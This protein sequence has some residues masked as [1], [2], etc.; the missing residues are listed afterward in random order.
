VAWGA[1]LAACC[2]LPPAFSQPPAEPADPIP[3]K[4]VTV[5]AAGAAQ[6]ARVAQEMERLGLTALDRIPIDDFDGR[7]RRARTAARTAPQLV[8]ARYFRAELVGDALVGKG[9]WRVLHAGTEA[10][11][12]PLGFLT[13]ALRQPRFDTRDAIVAEFEGQ[14]AGLLVEGE[15]D[16]TVN[17]DWSARQ[18]PESEGVQFQLGLP[19]CAVASLELDLPANL[20]VAAD[21]LPVTGPLLAEKAELKR[22]RVVFSRRPTLA[23]T[24][25]PRPEPGQPRA[26]LAGP[27]LT[28]QKL[29]S[30]AV[31]VDFAFDH[32]KVQSGEFRELTCALDPSL[33]PYDVTAPELE[34]WEVRPP[35]APGAP[36][37]LI[38]RLREALVSGTLVVRCFAPLG[39][40]EP[41]RWTAPG[42]RL[43]DAVP[44]GE[45]LLLTVH[46]DVSLD[47][48]EPGGFRLVEVRGDADGQV[49]KLVGGLLTDEAGKPAGASRPS[50]QLRAR[51]AEFRARQVALWKVDPE[52]SSFMARITYEVQRG[53]LFRLVLE[54]PA[55]YDL[56]GV[57]TEQDGQIRNWETRTE[58]GKPTLIVDLAQPLAPEAKLYLLVRLRP[59]LP[60]SGALAWSIPDL[61][62]LGAR[63]RE[64][65]LAIDFD[66]QRFEGRV[67]GAAM[68]TAPP[69][70]DYP[71]G[72]DVPDYYG[73]YRG[74]PLRGR[75]ELRPVPPRLRVRAA[76]RVVLAPGHVAAATTLQLQAEAGSPQSLDVYVSAAVPGR[77]DW[78]TTAGSNTVTS[79]KR[80]PALEAAARLHVLAARSPLGAAALLAAP[81]RGEWRRLTLRR[82]LKPRDVLT[83]QAGCELQRGADDRWDVPLL[84][85]PGADPA[86]GEV[87]LDLA[88]AA[89]ARIEASGLHAIQP[90]SSRSGAV[91]PW[92]T[93]R[94]G[95]PPVALILHGAALSLDPANVGAIDRA[96]LTTGV[97]PDGRLVHLFRFQAWG[98][99]APSLPLRL[100]AGACLLSVKVDGRWVE[101][102]PPI[103]GEDGGLRVDLPAPAPSDGT[104][105][106]APRRYEVVYTTASS[107][108]VLW[109]R[110]E[111]P[112]PGLPGPPLTFQRRW[113]LPPGLLP[114]YDGQVRALPAASTDFDGRARGT[115]DLTKL[116][117][118]VLRPLALEEW[119]TRQRDQLRAAAR[120]LPAGAGR[121]FTLGEAL[122]RMACD[123]STD[124]DPLV[125][126]AL[127]LE[128]AGLT[129]QTLL[130]PLAASARDGAPFWEALGLVQVPCRPAPLLTTQRRRDAWQAAGHDA[131][132]VPPAVEAAVAEA[133]ANGHDTSGR[134]QWAAAWARRSPSVGRSPAGPWLFDASVPG[135]TEWEP[136]AGAGADTALTTI[137][138]APIRA[139]GIALAV[140]LLVGLWGLRRQSVR[141]R[142]ALLLVGLAAAVAGL[143][144][145]PASLHGLALGPLFAGAALGLAWYLWSLARTGGQDKGQ[146]T[147]DKSSI[148]K[149]PAA[150]FVLCPLS[151]TLVAA[152]EAAPPSPTRATVLVVPGP[153]EAPD[154]AMVL[155]PHELV[156]Q[157]DALAS[158]GAPHGAVIAGATYDGKVAGADAEFEA[159]LHLQSFE[160]GLATLALPFADVRLQDDGLLDGARAYLKA[161]PTGQAGFVL[162][163]EKPGS[164]VLVMRF[165]VTVT[166]NG[167][168][169]EVRF[170]APRLPQSQLTLAVP[171]GAT[172]FQALVRQGALTRAE[173]PAGTPIARYTTELGR[174][175]GPL[176]FHWHEAVAAPPPPA[177]RV[178]EA[179]LWS[180][181]PDGASLQAVL[182]YSVTQGEPT[183][184]AVEVPEALEVLGAEARS[185]E[186]SRPAPLLKPW[187]TETV[188]GK[189]QLRLDF[190]API[191]GGVSLVLHLVPRRPLAAVA[192]LPLPNPLGAVVERGYLAYRTEG[193]EA[194]VANSGRLRGPFVGP[195]GA[196]ELKGYAALWQTAGE[197][198]PSALAV[199]YGVQREPGGDPFLQVRLSISPPVMM[200]T[201]EVT[202]RVGP[203]QADLRA[204]VRLTAPAGDLP[205][206]EWEVPADVAVTRVGGRGRR[207]PVR[208]WSRT[209]TRVQVWLDRTPGGTEVELSGWKELVPEAD[210]ARFD[211]PSVRLLSADVPTT[212]VRLTAAA[213]LGLRREETASLLPLPEPHTSARDMS[214]RPLGPSYSGRFHVQR[215][216]TGLGDGGLPHKGDGPGQGL[217]PDPEPR[218]EGVAPLRVVLTERVSA[219]VDGR[220]WAHEAVLWLYH[221][222][223]TDLHVMLPERANV[224]AVTVD[225]LA[226][227][228]LPEAADRLGVPLPG[229]A[230]ACRVRLRWAF[231]P[232]D[233][234]FDRPRL[235]R[236]R[237]PGAED[238]PVVWT[239]HIPAEYAASFAPGG[240]R[241]TPSGL[242]ASELARATAQYRLSE[243]LAG[244]S[245]PAQTSA[246]ARTQ[247]HFYQLCRY[248]EA[249]R[250]LTGPG[251]PPD[252]EVQLR[253]LKENDS[254]LAR[255]HNFDPLRERAE[256]EADEATPLALDAGAPHDRTDA[257]QTPVPRGD[258]LPER[259]VPLRWQTGPEADAPHL[260]L[261]PLSTHQAR[262]ALGAS[263]LLGLLLAVI[264][265]LAYFPGMLAWVRAFWPEQVALL[266]CLGWQTYGPSVPLLL[267]IALGVSG[268]L[269]L[270]GRRALVLL[271]RPP[272]DPSH[273]GSTGSGLGTEPRPSG[274]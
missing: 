12:L 255:D 11:V 47:A 164:H 2:L 29:T 274:S 35:A 53:R 265:A 116:A 22:W 109:A 51:G 194:P 157:I 127:A 206:I 25:R 112:S 14:G 220:R 149:L 57:K 26:L 200:G 107:A 43:V 64:G 145:L 201:Q 6:E 179:Y 39:V 31:E 228:P 185:A 254:R 212:A 10:A 49:L 267:L 129:Q 193:V 263:A 219:V 17:F 223:N 183:A 73:T 36:T 98:W 23:L 87:S 207:E 188:G 151:F 152:G 217:R 189:R 242:A 56:E 66:E 262:R 168:E 268:R 28:R 136:V 147:K 176:V 38:V 82:P 222:A 93:F 102:V 156:K 67:T 153:P 104:P 238:G 135:W 76:V 95:A 226:V 227:T 124:H 213:D 126:D 172:F 170:R 111:V 272:A 81:A 204:V 210:G 154:R 99:T 79:F 230:G 128:E 37:M 243:S 257:G 118:L 208:H 77:W 264:W 9:Q 195:A 140:L 123:A 86:D 89:M 68:S 84:A 105:G 83:L 137:R 269:F 160:D 174:A 50:T 27:L 203:R 92:R 131:G 167:S 235:Q 251:A 192:T 159:T 120:A 249:A 60:P 85:V 144:W 239:V 58:R 30:D 260:V 241:E 110:F 244:A 216:A 218:P 142:L 202:W 186:A 198:P 261:T 199:L 21:G 270:L 248:A 143:L 175:D 114:L 138:R 182:H 113:R 205:L 273:G 55:G 48:W 252:F 121:E 63:L 259:G 134:F 125:I 69:G 234:P 80:L 266:G 240:G 169:R 236:P 256:R 177:L 162:R 211:L 94:Y 33:R 103:Q 178:R 13:V 150:L 231:E 253:Q 139:A 246:L 119:E 74:T 16:H 221:E 190:A 8:E 148:L 24:L 214:F 224:L 187:H 78:Q 32:L 165:R 141:R 171:A 91:L 166:A 247:R 4:R 52:R 41:A 115:E 258:P 163:I 158:A 40:A 146:R 122:E 44:G 61:V 71:R 155:A 117:A 245:G 209:G 18:K 229:A 45:T 250:Q 232:A 233:E 191:T 46:P 180:L 54:L 7:L 100:P 215:L 106:R 181:R 19:E 15:G 133:A 271:H 97:E 196:P 1:L 62:P 65:G 90:A 173:A 59:L 72:W 88:G 197:A 5:P 20:L 101:R 75:L 3:I 96:V 70:E 161:A 34:G 237:L 42:L 132:A 184:L 225:G 108:G 130:A